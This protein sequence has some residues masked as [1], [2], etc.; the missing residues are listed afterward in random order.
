MSEQMLINETLITH[1]IKYLHSANGP[2]V[3]SIP[4]HSLDRSL[5]L[6]LSRVRI[7]IAVSNLPSAGLAPVRVT[8]QFLHFFLDHFCHSFNSS[9]S[10]LKIF[11][12]SCSSFCSSFS[13]SHSCSTWVWIS[14][15]FWQLL[16]VSSLCPF[17]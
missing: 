9:G 7:Q 12:G 14:G 1:K 17:L 3:G 11:S 15:A 4:T 6:S 8:L 16:H 10:S 2:H 5:S 13:L